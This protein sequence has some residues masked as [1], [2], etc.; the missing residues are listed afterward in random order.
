MC[1]GEVRCRAEGFATRQDLGNLPARNVATLVMGQYQYC[2]ELRN[3][4]HHT[5][6]L[7]YHNAPNADLSFKLVDD[8]ETYFHGIS[9]AD[10]E[11]LSP[12]QTIAGQEQIKEPK[13]N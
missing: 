10:I 4:I 8:S 6:S 2:D 5:F 12:C 3:D 11:Y 7:S 9:N 1:L 13:A